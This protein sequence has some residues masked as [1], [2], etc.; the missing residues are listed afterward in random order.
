MVYLLQIPTRRK[1]EITISPDKRKAREH[2]SEHTLVDWPKQF[3]HT[4]WKHNGGSRR[5]GR[6]VRKRM[7]LWRKASLCEKLF[8][9]WHKVEPLWCFTGHYFSPLALCIAPY[10][11]VRASPKGLAS[12]PDTAWFC[13]ALCLCFCGSFSSRYLPPNSGG[14]KGQ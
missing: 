4:E 10:R 7:N 9:N 8:E 5:D 12:R 6:W 13:Q 3:P 11:T 14:S 1:K 2:A